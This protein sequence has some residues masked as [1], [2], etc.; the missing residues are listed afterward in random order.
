MNLELAT[1]IQA[2]YDLCR[3]LNVFLGIIVVF[4][5]GLRLAESIRQKQALRYT[6]FGILFIGYVSVVSYGSY[7]SEMVSNTATEASVLIT[8]LNLGV[9][10]LNVAAAK[11]PYR[12][13]GDPPMD[14]NKIIKW[15]EE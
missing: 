6:V 14:E 9:I 3:T 11:D 1:Q 2:I 12:R 4:T 15:D 13:Y 7:R 10:V 8:L 5:M